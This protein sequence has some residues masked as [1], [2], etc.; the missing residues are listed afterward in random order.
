M[1]TIAESGTGS[2][3][4]FIKSLNNSLSS[5]CF[6]EVNFV[7]RISTPHSSKTPLSC[8]LTAKFKAT[9]P[10]NVGKSA[11]GFSFLII[12]DKNSTVNGSIYTLSAISLSVII[13]AGFEFTS[14]TSYPSSLKDKQACVPA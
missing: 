2:F 3:N 1:W 10:P 5:A 12:F 13:V 8:R 9:C 11:S 4:S 6:I 14:I 7:P